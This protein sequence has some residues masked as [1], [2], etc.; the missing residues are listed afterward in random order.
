MFT[1]TP[2]A[3]GGGPPPPPLPGPW[4]RVGTNTILT[5]IGDFVGIGIALP[6]QKLDVAGNANVSGTLFAAVVQ[7]GDLHL[8][9]DER[10]AHWVLIE[11]TDRIVA[12]NKITGKRYAIAL[13][14][15]ED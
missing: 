1:T 2:G 6:T 10:N 7:A 13:T 11:E 4:T 14:P 15:I 9:D 3:S 12:I 8:R 5:N